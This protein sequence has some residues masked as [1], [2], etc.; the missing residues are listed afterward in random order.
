MDIQI[1]REEKAKV[2]FLCE[3]DN[4]KI[5]FLAKCIHE[6]IRANDIEE[7][8]KQEETK[9]INDTLRKESE[10]YCK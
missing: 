6:I 10:Q 1:S 4:R 2:S 5:A 8:F 9:R 7:E 3:D